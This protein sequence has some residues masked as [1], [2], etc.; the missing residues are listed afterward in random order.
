MTKSLVSQMRFPHVL[1][2]VLATLNGHW[3]HT[4]CCTPSGG[5]G[6][7]GFDAS[8]WSSQHFASHPE[9]SCAFGTWSHDGNLQHLKSP[10]SRSSPAEGTDAFQWPRS[11]KTHAATK[12]LAFEC[13]QEMMTIGMRLNSRWLAT[14]VSGAPTSSDAGKCQLSR[15]LPDARRPK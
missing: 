14:Y 9:R 10:S 2:T 13:W 12:G 8:S 4:Q 11:H 3:P 6:L 15:E 5:K 7:V 1:H